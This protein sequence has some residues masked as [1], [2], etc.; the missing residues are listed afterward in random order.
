MP[1]P[2]FHRTEGEHEVL[3]A[4]TF[5]KRLDDWLK[6]RSQTLQRGKGVAKT[7]S[8]KNALAAT[9]RKTLTCR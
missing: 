9:P 8:K 6:S 1:H 5:E 3:I 7:C 4:N 2:I